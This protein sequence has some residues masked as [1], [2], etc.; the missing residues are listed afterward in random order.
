MKEKS[1]PPRQPIT[2]AVYGPKPHRRKT[3]PT[4]EKREHIVR[5]G[6]VRDALLA[7]L[8]TRAF[9]GLLDQLQRAAPGAQ[10]PR[11]SRGTR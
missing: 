11:R 7:K 10:G 9:G 1:A 8:G 4:T 3:K 6:T 5:E 2:A